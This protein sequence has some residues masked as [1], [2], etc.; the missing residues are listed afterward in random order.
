[1]TDL[2]LEGIGKILE[3]CKNCG[4]DNPKLSG[5]EIVSIVPPD[6]T[7]ASWTTS[8]WIGLAVVGGLLVLAII[9]IFGRRAYKSRMGTQ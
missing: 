2:T 8:L 3:T 1:M 5:D 7:G 4:V 9:I 6:G